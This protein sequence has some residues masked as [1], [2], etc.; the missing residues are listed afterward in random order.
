MSKDYKR[1]LIWETLKRN[2][3]PE[4]DKIHYLQFKD[5]KLYGKVQPETDALLDALLDRVVE[6]NKKRRQ[7]QGD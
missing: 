1:D 5:Q 3:G 6:D 2:Y 7:E 4:L